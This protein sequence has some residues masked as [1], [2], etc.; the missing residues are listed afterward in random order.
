MNTMNEEEM[1]RKKKEE[2]EM[3]Q[4]SP[5]KGMG[6]DSDKEKTDDEEY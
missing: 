4:E 2:E 3:G 5:D 6:G 1:R